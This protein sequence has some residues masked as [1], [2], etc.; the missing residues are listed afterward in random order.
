MDNEIED[1]I[2]AAANALYEEGGRQ[3]FPTVD[4]V[5]KAVRASMNDVCT[6]MRTWRNL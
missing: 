4:V 6:A 1:R 2:F 5:R 3:S